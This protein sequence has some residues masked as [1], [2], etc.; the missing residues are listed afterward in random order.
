MIA[1]NGAT[2]EHS[3]HRD[4]R[5]LVEGLFHGRFEL[6]NGFC[7]L[8]ETVNVAHG[9][10]AHVILVQPADTDPVAFV[11]RGKLIAER[12]GRRKETLLGVYQN[13]EVENAGEMLHPCSGLNGNPIELIDCWYVGY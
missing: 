7:F 13:H 4:F 2:A 10:N 3:R 1:V 9:L 6:L 5:I 11:T 12:H 8:V